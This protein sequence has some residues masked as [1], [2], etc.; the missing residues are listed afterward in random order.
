MQ[1]KRPCWCSG[2][3]RAVAARAEAAAA[4]R[5]HSQRAGAYSRCRRG[6]AELSYTAARL[7]RRR[8]PVTAGSS[9][10]GA[11]SARGPTVWA[12]AA[13][14]RQLLPS[15]GAA[16]PESIGRSSCVSGD[17]LDRRCVPRASP[18][19]ICVGGAYLARLGRQSAS[20]VRTSR[21]SGDRLRQRP[22]SPETIWIGGAYLARLLRPACAQGVEGAD[23]AALAE[24]S[25]EPG[26]GRESRGT[27]GRA[28]T[29]GV[30]RQTTASAAT[31]GDG[32]GQCV[33]AST[34]AASG[35]H[36]CRR[37]GSSPAPGP[38][39]RHVCTAAG[40]SVLG[41]RRGKRACAAGARVRRPAARHHGR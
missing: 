1:G 18:E 6:A 7:R 35:L 26:C 24:Q 3:T 28:T 17:N 40:E 27:W 4:G 37:L 14:P 16:R 41:C 19:T 38:R 30:V 25:G 31:Q 13:W 23:G 2:Q 36:G 10:P 29:R 12:R 15:R 9:R 8:L 32:S 11:C 39:R 34:G 22:A 20:A 5:E 33:A 21:V